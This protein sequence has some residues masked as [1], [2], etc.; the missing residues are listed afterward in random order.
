MAGAVALPKAVRRLTPDRVRE[1]VL[2]RALAV[3]SGAIP[4]RTMHSPAES[5]LLAELA[6]GRERLVEIG[7]YEG[8]SAVVLARAAAPG[9]TLHLIDPFTGTALRPGQRGTE[10]ATRRVVSRAARERGG[11]RLEWHIQRS[12]EAAAAWREP[13]DLVWIDGDHSEAS[14][15]LDWELWSRWVRPGGVVGFHDA[16]AGRA[17]GWGLPGPTAVVDE[18]FRGSRPLPGWRIVREADTAVA[19]VRMGCELDPEIVG[20]G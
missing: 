10:R 14:C 20:T 16:R 6:A 2:L 1:S 9:A 4:P 18:L 11:P 12:D 17:G 3:G 8:S 19:I 13:V 15:R 5:A 7:V